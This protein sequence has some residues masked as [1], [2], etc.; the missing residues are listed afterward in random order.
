M[1]KAIILVYLLCWPDGRCLEPVHAPFQ[2]RTVEA[3]EQVAKR[4]QERMALR[5][6]TIP[7]YTCKEDDR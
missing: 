2:F 4:A 1:T 5:G 7:W 6:L 3:C